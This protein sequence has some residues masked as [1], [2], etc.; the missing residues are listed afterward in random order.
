MPRWTGSARLSRA[1]I[2]AAAA[3]LFYVERTQFAARPA[4]SLPTRLGRETHMSID[5]ATRANLELTRTL[6]GAREGSLIGAIDSTVTAAGG[7]LLAERLAAPLTSAQDIA[8]RQDSIAFFIDEPELRRDV[9]A[10][11]KAAPDLTRGR[12]PPRAR[13][14]RPA[15]SRRRARGPPGRRGAGR[16]ARRGLATAPPSR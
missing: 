1:E 15:R 8:R 13:S 4:L 7:R 16:S 6:G 14:R 2:A 11:L 5:A 12:R 10:I 3:A 9:R